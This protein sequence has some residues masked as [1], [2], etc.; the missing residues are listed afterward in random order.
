MMAVMLYTSRVVLAALGVEDYG[1]YE[2]V[3]GVVA[4]FSMISNLLSSAIS[5]FITYEL[6]RG[7]QEKLK[8]IFSTSLIIQ[9]IIGFVVVLLVESVG[10]WFLTHKMV[11]PPDRMLAAKWVLQFSLITLVINLISI[12][13]NATIIA[14]ERMSAFAYISIVEA[15]GKLGIAYL[16]T[17]SPMDNLIFYAI[18]MSLVAL[19][20]RLCYG[21]YCKRHFSECKFSFVIDR[22]LLKEMFSFA[23]WNFIGS[24]SALLRDQGGN[25]LLNIM[26]GGPTVN[27]ARGIANQVNMAVNQF[28]NNFMIALNP[29][30]TKSYA[31]GDS[32]YMM[33]LLFQ[34][35]RFSFYLLFCLSLPIFVSTDYVLTLWLKTVPVHT[36]A[37][38]RLSLIFALSEVISRPLV[39]AQ[40][41]TGKI[42]NYQLVV[43]GLQMLNLPLAYL[44]LRLGY[45]VEMVYVVAIVVSFCCMCAR[46]YILRGEVGLSARAFCARV[47]FNI[48]KVVV[49]AV[50]VP[51]FVAS[52]FVIDDFVRFVVVSA[53]VVVS[54]L[55]SVYFVGLS[56]AERDYVKNFVRGFIKK[57][58]IRK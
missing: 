29:Q 17:I 42:R 12:P 26:G 19:V 44:C 28:S 30:I 3:G 4:M 11:I 56:R 52:R 16:V 43:G 54:C 41:A 14:H 38:V 5:R 6:G 34:G 58:R 15:L 7:N 1:I 22:T 9:I 50:I 18:L 13:Y 37:F 48:L 25:M 10:M 40:F 33:T 51:I 36:I 21:F 32:K 53:F 31:S 23:G 57:T 39:V 47:L 8:L 45:R 55:L 2:V 46:L 27:A 49:V 35:S 24:S 20:V